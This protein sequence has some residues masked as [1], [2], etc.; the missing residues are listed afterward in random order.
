MSGSDGAT[1]LGLDW[2]SRRIGVAVG[3]LGLGRARP[4]G[5]VVNRSGSPDWET[6]D[7]RV[8]EWRPAAFVVGWPLDEGD[9]DVIETAR[10]GGRRRTLAEAR[11]F[12]RRLRRRYGLPVHG[13][14]ER[15]S[16]IEAGRALAAMRRDG[17]RRRRVRRED[18]DAVAAALILERW[19]E[20]AAADGAGAAALASASGGGSDPG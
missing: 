5:T 6:L 4:L 20:T 14:D 12:A 16:S 19:F 15:Y 10:D 13:V 3:T 9:G 11:G 7:A 8:A 1:V 18:V 2:G 17:R